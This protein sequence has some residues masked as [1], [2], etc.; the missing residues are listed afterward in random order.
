MKKIKIIS[1]ICPPFGACP[2]I[3]E[4]GNEDYIVIGKLLNKEE[5]QFIKNKIGIDETAVKIP[6]NL[7]EKLNNL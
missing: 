5:L 2:T 3:L 7:I 4:S 6:K 1:Q